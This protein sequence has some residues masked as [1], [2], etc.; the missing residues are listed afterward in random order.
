[1]YK[2]WERKHAWQWAKIKHET[3]K[4]MWPHNLVPLTNVHKKGDIA[5][6]K[7]MCEK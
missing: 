1:M 4:K 3:T 7:A 2:Y 6:G 5:I